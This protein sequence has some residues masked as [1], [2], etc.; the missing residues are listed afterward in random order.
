MR[1]FCAVGFVNECT[2]ACHLLRAGVPASEVVDAIARHAR[3]RGKRRTAALARGYA[4]KTVA[5]PLKR[6]HR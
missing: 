6:P 4:E 2:F 5:A 3:E 1:H